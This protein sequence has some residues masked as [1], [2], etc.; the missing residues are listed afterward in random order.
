MQTKEMQ[1][2][3][4]DVQARVEMQEVQDRGQEVAAASVD[5]SD[6]VMVCAS[7]MCPQQQIDVSNIDREQVK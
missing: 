4:E 1:R 7:L 2:Q 3:V 5:S 6:V